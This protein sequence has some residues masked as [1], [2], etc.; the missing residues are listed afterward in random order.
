MASKSVFWFPSQ[1]RGGWSKFT[2]RMENST[3]CVSTKLCSSCDPSLSKQLSVCFL[4]LRG[5]LQ[6]RTMILAQKNA[7]INTKTESK[8]ITKTTWQEEWPEKK[9][10]QK[11][12]QKKQIKPRCSSVFCFVLFVFVSF[13]VFG[14][15]VC[16]FFC[17][18]CFFYY[19]CKT[20][21]AYS[22]CCW[23]LKSS[24]LALSNHRN[25][26]YL[27]NGEWRRT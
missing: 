5:R 26:N 8:K 15:L 11:K 7:I 21:Y 19:F 3:A 2:L 1:Q 6:Q 13:L 25:L 12:T 24:N 27:A 10:E 20:Q 4:A 18:L 16:F 22:L 23:T 9:Q 17:L 14:F